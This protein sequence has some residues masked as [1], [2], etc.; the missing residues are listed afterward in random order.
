MAYSRVV[1]VGNGTATQFTVNFALDYLLETDVTCRVGTE[2]DGSRDP[3]YRAITFLSTNLIEVAGAPAGNGVPIV[4]ERTVDKDVLRVNFTNGDQLDEDNLD[5]AQKQA[6]M[7]VQEVLDGRFSVFTQDLDMGGFKIKNLASPTA[8]SDAAT[9]DYVD[10]GTAARDEGAAASAAVATAQAVIATEQASV[11]T[12]Q[13]V[14]ATEQASA[15]MDNAALT[16]ADRVQTALDRAAVAADLVLVEAGAGQLTVRY[17]TGDG[18]TTDYPL[19]FNPG[20]A[21]NVFVNFTGASQFASDY[22]LVNVAG[23]TKVRFTV[24][25]PKNVAIE[26]RFGSSLAVNVPADGS[27]VPA[28]LSGIS[29]T[30]IPEGSNKYFNPAIMRG[31]LAGLVLSTAGASS[32]FSIAVGVATDSTNVDVISLT[33][34]MSKTTSAWAAGSGNGSLDTGTIAAST[35]Y[36]FFLIKNPTNGAADVVTSAT[37]TP[38]AGPTTLPIGYTLFRRI[39]SRKTDGSAKWVGFNQIGDLV[40][41]TAPVADANNL[42][43]STTSQTVP[44]TVPPG[45]NVVAVFNAT[46]TATNDVLLYS[47]IGDV[48]AANVPSGNYVLAVGLMSGAFQLLTDTSRNIRASA[49]GTDALYIATQGWID[50]RGRDA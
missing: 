25:P 22:T 38:N 42:A 49:T 37:V 36:H 19:P 3:I 46:K 24:A 14:I 50:R 47:G 44:L 2:V 34:A 4:F 35:W 43:V 41:L 5:T 45:L 13:A 23:V 17:F 18:V 29:T 32:T 16:E 10:A 28:S 20:V 12:A 31:Y 26:L 21:A 11:S 27:V 7:A 8:S 40:Q 1:S 33:S 48:Q 9:K 30:N 15:A 6:M 39:G